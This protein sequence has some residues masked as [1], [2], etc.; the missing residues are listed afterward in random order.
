MQKIAKF[1]KVSP[2]QFQTDWSDTFGI[3]PDNNILEE[4]KLPRR[5]T[6]GPAGYDIYSPLDFEL[7]PGETIK[8]PTGLRCRI[9]IGWV[10]MIYPRGGLGFKYRLQ[11]N[12]TVGVIDSDYYTAKNE[13]H[14]FIKI[15][16]DP[17]ENKTVSIKKGDAFAQGV[18]TPF[19]ITTDDAADGV[20]YGGMG[21]TDENKKA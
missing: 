3:S 10:L 13:G 17:N 12:N 16:N 4:I 1:T 8:I 20:R 5:A 15:T 6:S 21:S 18:F 2:H 11:M 7:R 19:G 9:D 14:I